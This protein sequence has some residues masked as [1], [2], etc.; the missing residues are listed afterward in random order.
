M[1][2]RGKSR[3]SFAFFLLS[4]SL[5]LQVPGQQKANDFTKRLGSLDGKMSSFSGRSSK[6]NRLSP[7]S[8]LRITVDE[9]PSH[10]SPFGGKRFPMGNVKILGKE[11]IPSSNIEIKTPLNDRIAGESFERVKNQNLLKRDQ[12]VHSIEFRD[13]YYAQLNDRV[14]EWM[15]KVNNM[16]L[17]DINRYQFR[18]DRP[19]EPGF[20]VQRAGAGG[21]EGSQRQTSIRDSGLPLIKQNSQKQGNRS[22]WMGPKKVNASSSSRSRASTATDSDFSAPRA[23]SP[24]PPKNFKARPKPILGPK[25]I[26]VQVDNSE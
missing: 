23:T 16:S 6:L 25:T 8:A 5:V 17:R 20:P 7:S 15:D 12:A 1:S 11:R 22:Y 4:S 26:R 9:W 14:D 24:V 10:F 18:R 19:K 13:A 21:L 3:I 2:V